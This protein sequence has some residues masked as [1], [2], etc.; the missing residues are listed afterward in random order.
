MAAVRTAVVRTAV[1]RTAVVRSERRSPIATTAAVLTTAASQGS[2]IRATNCPPVRCRWPSTIRLVR[3]DPGSSKEP[4]LDS[5]RQPYSSADPATT[6]AG[7][8]APADPAGRW[9]AAV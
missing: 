3:L 8:G 9:L 6:A 2:H 1:V 7:P 5:S 4:A